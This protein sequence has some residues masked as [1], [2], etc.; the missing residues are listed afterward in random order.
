MAREATPAGYAQWSSWIAS[1]RDGEGF[2]FR[3]FDGLAATNLLYL[4]SDMMEVEQR[5]EAMNQEATGSTNMAAIAET[6]N[7]EALLEHCQPN[8]PRYTEAKKRMDLILE[9][10]LKIK[11]YHEALLLQSRLAQLQRPGARVIGALNDMMR[12]DA[13]PKIGGKA[14]QYLQDENDLVALGSPAQED[15]L[16]QFLRR[17]LA[18]TD[19][20]LEPA[21][22]R[23]AR[24]DESTINTILNIVTIATATFSLVGPIVTLYLIQ[25]HWLKLMLVAVFTLSFA[26]SVAV[27]TKAKRPEIFVGTATYAAVL[28][29]FISSG[30]LTGG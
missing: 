14:K 7:W 30:S 24:F 11:E 27:V 28:V 5:L 22:P 13:I 6:C 18:R 15:Y 21:M 23:V 16:S 10:R 9:L 8:H 25:T 12:Q 2:V 3:R 20:S 4:Q 1:D 17:R 29:V 26:A 19:T